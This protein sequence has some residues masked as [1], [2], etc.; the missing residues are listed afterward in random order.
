MVNGFFKLIVRSLSFAG[1]V[2][3]TSKF[4]S[5]IVKTLKPEIYLS[6][7]G[8]P[9]IQ[10]INNGNKTVHQTDQDGSFEPI[11]DPSYISL[12]NT[13]KGTVARDC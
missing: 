6:R 4:N 2:N 11:F 1:V 9:L 5:I 13:F 8:V 10:K 12:D 7:R 3:S